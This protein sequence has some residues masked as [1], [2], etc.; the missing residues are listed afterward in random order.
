[1]DSRLR[2][3]LRDQKDDLVQLLDSQSWAMFEAFMA[4]RKD[5]FIQQLIGAIKSDDWNK[6]KIYHALMTEVDSVL[7][8]FKKEPK[9]LEGII[10]EGNRS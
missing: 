2:E 9:R 8:E 6:T 10:D 4:R 7:A 1:M 5:H 3:R